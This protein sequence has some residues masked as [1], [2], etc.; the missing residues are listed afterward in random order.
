LRV[1]ALEWQ[2]RSVPVDSSVEEE[3]ED[4]FKVVTAAYRVAVD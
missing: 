3:V 4:S 1:A 2:E